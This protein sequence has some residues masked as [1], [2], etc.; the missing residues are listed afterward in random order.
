[1]ILGAMILVQSP[2]PEMRIHLTTAI[3]VTLPFAVITVFLLS[4]IVRARRSKVITG[5][6]GMIDETGVAQTALNPSGKIFVHGEFWDAIASTP[7][8]AGARVKVVEVDG[9]VL[10][11]EPK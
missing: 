5:A 9:L 6:S 1:M 7:V 11:V 8:E 4:L 2:L 10:K 3:G